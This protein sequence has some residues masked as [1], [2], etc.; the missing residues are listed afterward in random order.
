MKHAV[1]AHTQAM[2]NYGDP[3][4]PW[5]KR[6]AGDSYWVCTIDLPKGYE[7]DKTGLLNGLR[8]AIATIEVRDSPMWIETVSD[9]EL[10]SVA[11]AKE[12]SEIDWR[13]IDCEYEDFVRH[14]RKG[15]CAE[16]VWHLAPRG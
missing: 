16:D 2:E 13:A 6:K 9:I 1:I 8:D 5:W 12:R 7:I 4:R 10:V 15:P 14:V 11:E 3:E